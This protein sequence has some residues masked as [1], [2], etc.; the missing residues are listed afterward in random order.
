MARTIDGDVATQTASKNH[1]CD[2]TGCQ[3]W[4]VK[5]QKY[6]RVIHNRNDKVQRF[7]LSCYRVQFPHVA[8]TR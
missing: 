2:R 8:V 3:D 7:H 1:Q 4:I 6:R 5:G